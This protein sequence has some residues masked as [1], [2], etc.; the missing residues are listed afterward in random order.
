MEYFQ[1]SAILLLALIAIFAG[2]T[3]YNLH[4]IRFL[5]EEMKDKIE[6]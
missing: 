1:I 4:K 3:D 5:L 6:K 2:F